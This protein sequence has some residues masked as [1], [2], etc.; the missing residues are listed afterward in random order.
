M[1]EAPE[2]FQVDGNQACVE[3]GERLLAELRKGKINYFGYLACEGPVQYRTELVGAAGSEFS[4]NFAVDELKDS[5]RANVY[6]KQSPRT[7]ATRPRNWVVFN[8]AS[9]PCSFDFLA[10]LMTQ[11]MERVKAGCT[12]PLMV[13][14]W[15]GIDQ[16]LERCLASG[17]RKLMY[18]NVMLPLIEMIGGHRWIPNNPGEL[19]E[20]HWPEMYTLADASKLGRE[21]IAAPLLTPTA[22]AVNEVVDHLKG[23]QPVVIVLREAEHW[24]YRNSNLPEW[25]RF[26]N[27]CLAGEDVIFLRDTALASVSL[28]APAYAYAPAHSYETYPAA[29]I[30]INVRVALYQRAKCVLGVSNGPM[31]LAFHTKTP[32]M[33]FGALDPSRNYPPGRAEW[34][35]PMHGI[36]AGGQFPWSGPDQRIVWQ[37]DTFEI[38]SKAWGEFTRGEIPFVE[39]AE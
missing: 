7:S 12:A 1:Q 16:N 28:T 4:A 38:L 19:Q 30:D 20:A 35:P 25:L 10:W 37:P 8:I 21:G 3:L 36:P 27:E 23:R 26:T 5:V 39:A 31:T 32:W 2:D 18:L 11:E 22:E 17:A 13:G 9:G 6:R 24:N 33:M 29:S 14:I 34:W 15:A